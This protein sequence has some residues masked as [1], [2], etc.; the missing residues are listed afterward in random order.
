MQQKIVVI[1]DPI[2]LQQTYLYSE[3]ICHQ[4]SISSTLYLS[5]LHQYFCVKKLQ[6]Q[7]VTKEKL[8][9]ELLFEKFARKML[10]KL[11]PRETLFSLENF[12]NKMSL[13]EKNFN[14][15]NFNFETLSKSSSLHSYNFYA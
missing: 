4:V 13:T 11:N 14:L 15:R 6:S 2:F 7:N 5:L 10:M 8:H 12:P 9:K 3:K 1:F